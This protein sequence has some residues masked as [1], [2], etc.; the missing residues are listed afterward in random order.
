M[1][2]LEIDLSNM[3]RDFSEENIETWIVKAGLHK[4]WIHNVAIKRRRKHILS[5]ATSRPLSSHERILSTELVHNCPLKE[6]T[7]PYWINGKPYVGFM[8]ECAYYEHLLEKDYEK[9]SVIC[10]A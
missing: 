5:Q 1:S 3:P 4:C 10:D 9:G 2:C 6:Y 7:K 8:Y